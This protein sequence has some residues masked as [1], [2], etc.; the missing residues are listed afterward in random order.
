[1]KTRGKK[2]VA[3]IQL[4]NN[5]PGLYIRYTRKLKEIIT[6]RDN[7]YFMKKIRL[8][9]VLAIFF[10]AAQETSAQFYFFDK[11]HY[12]THLVFETGGSVGIMNCLTDAGG[13]RGNGRPFL[14]DL[15]IGN[16]QVNGSIFLSA[17]YKYAVGLRLEGTFGTVKGYDSISLKSVSEGRYE[18][19]LS[20]KSKISEISLVAEFHI[21][22]ILSSYLFEDDLN[23]DDEPPRLSPYL[24]AGVGYFSFNPQAKLNS[25]W[26]DL[27][28][29]STEG[30]G[31]AE[32]PNR[33]PYKLAQINFPVGAGLKYELSPTINLRLELLHRILKTDYLDDLSMRYINPNLFPKYFTGTRLSNAIAL[34]DRR[35]KTNPE[36]PISPTGGQLRGNPKNNDSYFTFNFKVGI[37]FGR[38]LIRRSGPQRF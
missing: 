26:I 25:N 20:F 6:K 30:Q 7:N 34:N 37:T 22:F 31:F 9:L 2:G 12:D 17:L 36:Y 1:M 38:E 21:L 19:N 13:K 32:Y 23:I 11:D 35:S 8:I 5:Y 14:K 3:E 16:N 10:V 18:R 33:K 4:K 15:T 24:A 29:L 27:Q 28:P